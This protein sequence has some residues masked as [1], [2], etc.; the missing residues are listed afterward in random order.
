ME[1]RYRAHWTRTRTLTLN[2]DPNPNP[3]KLNPN[4]NPNPNSN[5]HPHPHLNSKQVLR[6]SRCRSLVISPLVPSI[7]PHSSLDITP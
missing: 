6:A 4:P 7:S 5:P 1:P 2:P 3:P